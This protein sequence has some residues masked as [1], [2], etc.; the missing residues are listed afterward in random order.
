MTTRTTARQELTQ[1]ELDGLKTNPGNCPRWAWHQFTYDAELDGECFWCGHPDPQPPVSDP[2]I[3]LTP[4]R[5]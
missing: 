4:Q 1:E 3:P 2:R 5:G